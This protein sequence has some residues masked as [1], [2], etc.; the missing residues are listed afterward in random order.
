MTTW[1]VGK[2]KNAKKAVVAQYIYIY[3]IL[4]ANSMPERSNTLFHLFILYRYIFLA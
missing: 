4:K 3:Y 1:P 2:K